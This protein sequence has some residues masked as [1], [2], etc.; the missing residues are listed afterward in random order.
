MAAKCTLCGNDAEYG[1]MCAECM[2]GF[3]SVS[4]VRKA[5]IMNEDLKKNDTKKLQNCLSCDKLTT[6]N[7]ICK[8]CVAEYLPK[9]KEFIDKHPELDNYMRVNFHKELPIPRRALYA[10]DQAGLI[11]I[12]TK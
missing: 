11:K 8:A 3:S 9:L 2:Q 1:N 12:R 4:S 7:K 5:E 10:L 6:D